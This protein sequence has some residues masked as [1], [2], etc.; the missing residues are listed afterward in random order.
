MLSVIDAP[1]R[2]AARREGAL[3]AFPEHERQR[4]ALNKGRRVNDR[5]PAAVYSLKRAKALH[6]KGGTEG[7]SASQAGLESC[8]RAKL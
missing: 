2:G 3:L 7:N 1:R 4:A 6:G 5:S 8:P